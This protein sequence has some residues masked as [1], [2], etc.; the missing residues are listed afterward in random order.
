MKVVIRNLSQK[1]LLLMESELGEAKYWTDSYEL[2]DSEFSLYDVALSDCVILK[3]HFD[4]I[5]LDRGGKISTIYE[6]DFERIEIV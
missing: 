4:S 2:T 5:T 1:A 3:T 6:D